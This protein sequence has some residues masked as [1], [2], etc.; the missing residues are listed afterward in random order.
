MVNLHVEAFVTMYHSSLS[1]FMSSK[2]PSGSKRHCESTEP[3][4]HQTTKTFC[5][6]FFQV[7]TALLV[8]GSTLTFWIPCRLSLHSPTRTQASFKALGCSF[9]LT[10]MW[11]DDHAVQFIDPWRPKRR[12]NVI[13][14]LTTLPQGYVST[15]KHQCTTAITAMWTETSW[16]FPES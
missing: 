8:A 14:A 6:F 9:Q 16:A 10:H 15:S 7:A 11:R 4:G 2:T 3:E 13:A 1:A 5:F 12:Q